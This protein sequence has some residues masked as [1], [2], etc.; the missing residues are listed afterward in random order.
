MPDNT[1]NTTAANTTAAEVGTLLT[2]NFTVN[3]A[4]S[5]IPIYD[6]TNIPLRDFLLDVH[7]AH[8]GITK[9]QESCFLRNL[10]SK[11]Q[12]KAKRCLYRKTFNEY[13]DVV[14]H[15]KERFGPNNTYTYYNQM[16]QSA[17]MRQGESAN[18][19]Y[20]HINVLLGGAEMALKEEVGVTYNEDMIKALTNIALDIFIKGLPAD[21]GRSVDAI[22]PKTL[23]EALK[24]AVYASSSAWPLASFPI[25]DIKDTP[26][27]IY[28]AIINLLA[29][30]TLKNPGLDLGTTMDPSWDTLIIRASITTAP[31]LT[32]TRNMWNMWKA[33]NTLRNNPMMDLLGKMNNTL[34]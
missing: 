8:I 16:L 12:G 1:T 19:F 7:N 11:V 14:K 5:Q 2:S 4:T 21:S 9:E 15:L 22:K 24:E 34:G 29:F 17:R 31:K 18:D 10:L 13:T 6:G 30:T 25:L 27:I 26:E 3:Q 20:D 28:Q 33:Q 23:D 32:T